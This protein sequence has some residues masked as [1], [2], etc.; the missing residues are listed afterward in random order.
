MQ[1]TSDK[2]DHSRRLELI[3][4]IGEA[5][6]QSLVLTCLHQVASNLSMLQQLYD[7]GDIHA[8]AALTHDIKGVAGNLGLLVIEREAGQIMSVTSEKGM[9]DVQ[10]IRQLAT[11]VQETAVAI[12]ALLSPR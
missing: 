9:P 1:Y 11:A 6:W 3:D 12:K 10:L 5:E 7:A 4:E 2:I 8:I